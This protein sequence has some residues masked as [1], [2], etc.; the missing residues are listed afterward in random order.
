MLIRTTVFI[1]WILCVLLLTGCKA[2][3]S[4][5]I[6]IKELIIK[7]V[8]GDQLDDSTYVGSVTGIVHH[9]NRFYISEYETGSLLILDENLNL[10]RKNRRKG[11]GPTEMLHAGH[12]C[13]VNDTIY[14]SDGGKNALLVYSLKGDF[15]FP[16]SIDYIGGRFSADNTAN[17][18]YSNQTG[19]PIKVFNYKTRNKLAFGNEEPTTRLFKS[20]A[21]ASCHVLL[22]TNYQII[23]IAEYFPVIFR[24]NNDGTL[25]DSCDLSTL[26]ILN[27]RIKAIELLQQQVSHWSY[28]FFTDACLF[29]DK[30]YVMCSLLKPNERVQNVKSTLLELH[31]GETIKAER[32]YTFPNEYSHSYYACFSI[33]ESQNKINMLAFDN[34]T[35]EFHE[36]VVE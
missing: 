16:I 26:P 29:K 22:T 34:E 7:K 13:I 28:F 4:Q 10:I 14:Q 21:M 30:L 31:V 1:N 24:Y 15:L 23:C 36:F 3:K 33:F 9:K 5:D 17:I 27:E 18:F 6:P 12:L 8:T 19:K 2:Y 20:S 25:S 11:K 32:F 35:K